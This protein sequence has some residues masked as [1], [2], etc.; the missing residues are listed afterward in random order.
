MV[1]YE[2]NRLFMNSMKT[3]EMNEKSRKII[4][5]CLQNDSY[6]TYYLP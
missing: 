4:R 6:L 5:V 2:T 3:V 1:S